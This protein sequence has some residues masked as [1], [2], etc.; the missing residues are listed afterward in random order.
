[1]REQV[2]AHCA[3]GVRVAEPLRTMDPRIFDAAPMLTRERT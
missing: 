1:V 3:P 2:L